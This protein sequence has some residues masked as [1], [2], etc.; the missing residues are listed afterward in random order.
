MEINNNSRDNIFNVRYYINKNIYLNKFRNIQENPRNNDDVRKIISTSNTKKRKENNSIKYFSFWNTICFK[1]CIINRMKRRF[2]RFAN[3][4]VDNK[5]S[6]EYYLEIS[7][8]LEFLKRLT[9]NEEQYEEFDKIPHLKF[10]EQ[11]KQFKINF[12][13]E[14]N[15]NI[16]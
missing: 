15:P 4:L 13:N 5:L 2:V 9:L 1:F 12:E 11:L 6:L 16:S 14:L 7:N 8:N 3:E 10:E